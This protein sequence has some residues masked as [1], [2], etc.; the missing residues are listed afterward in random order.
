MSLA[1]DIANDLDLADN[2]GSVTVQQTDP[3]TGSV[4]AT[5]VN[6]VVL[7]RVKRKSEVPVEEGEVQT[8][9]CRFH[10]KAAGMGFVPRERGRIV[11]GADTW[12][13]DAVDVATLATRYV[14][15][16]TKVRG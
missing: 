7:A 14:C 6:V 13:I 2:L 12:K 15:D 10:L 1:A 9:S 8:E 11:D 4:T 16:A 3:A 5:A